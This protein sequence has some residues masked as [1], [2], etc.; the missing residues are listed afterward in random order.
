MFR[1]YTQQNIP[2]YLNSIAKDLFVE[3]RRAFTQLGLHAHRILPWGA[4][5]L[6]FPWKGDRIVSTLYL[7][8]LH[9]KVR[10]ENNE[11]SLAVKNIK[12]SEV[13][14]ELKAI[15]KT[16]IDPLSLVVNIPDKHAEKHD[17]F[18]DEELLNQEFAAKNLNISGAYE[19]IHEL[20]G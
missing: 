4:D 15:A 2:S 3:G 14:E 6:L 19:A 9:R 16:T 7:L 11:L 12:E 18:L 13:R 17:C 1:I 8:L 20:I 5:V 10:V